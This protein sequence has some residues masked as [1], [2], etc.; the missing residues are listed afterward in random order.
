MDKNFLP[1]AK[2]SGAAGA[3]GVWFKQ[4]TPASLHFGHPSLPR[5]GK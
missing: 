3:E 5:R 4:T 2:G 1:L